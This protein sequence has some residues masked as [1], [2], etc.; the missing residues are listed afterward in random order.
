M[1]WFVTPLSIHSL[2]AV[3]R[4]KRNPEQARR[5]REHYLKHHAPSE[6]RQRHSKVQELADGLRKLEKE[7][8][9]V[10]VMKDRE[11][12]RETRMLVRGAYD[13]PG[14]K[15]APGTPATLPAMAEDAPR[16]R[17]GLARW[18]VDP[19]H[20]LTARV[21][22]N[23]YWQLH[24]G[25]GLVKTAEDFGTRGEWPSHP[26]L[27]DWLATEF[28][29]SGWDVKAM[30]RL[31]VT[32]ATYRQTSRLTPELLDRDPQNRLLARRPRLRLEAEVI[33][34]QALAISGLL[35][36]VIGGPSVKPCQPDGL[37]REVAFDTSGANLTAQVY[38]VG[39]GED[40]YRRSLYT[41]WKRTS[42]PPSMVLFDAP[43]R[44]RCVVRRSSTNTP[45]QALVVMNDP[46][47]VEAARKLAERMMLESEMVDGGTVVAPAGSGVELASGPSGRI[48]HGFRLAT[49]RWPSRQETSLLARVFE[50][51]LT[52]YRENPES[53][54]ALLAVGASPR[55][56][57][58]DVPELAAYAVIANLLL[59]L[60]ETLT[61]S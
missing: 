22:V 57:S 42:P 50:R 9:T 41:F 28:V 12:P 23:R 35:V 10:M 30:H 51:Q 17:L 13:R 11:G 33:R 21:A 4:S 32:S 6:W 53:A 20:P 47:F 61:R 56:A 3:D 7:L 18:L 2:L 19:A 52:A 54:A 25:T 43:D 1:I 24:F 37:W 34:D 29:R 45:L 14:E 44:E 39:K 8:P 49:G 46:L 59:N 16:N 48:G 15:V 36:G 5:I 27:L 40:L 55:D 38:E 58:L 26:E 60:D 31:I